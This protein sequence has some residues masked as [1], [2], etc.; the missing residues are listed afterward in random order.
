MRRLLMALLLG[1]LAALVQAQELTIDQVMEGEDFVGVSPSQVR[2]SGDNQHIYF[3]WREPDEKEEATYVISREGSGLRRLSKDEEEAEAWPRSG[4]WDRERE[5][6]LAVLQG[7]LYLYSPDGSRRALTQTRQRESNA[8]FSSDE[9]EVYFTRDNNLFTLSSQ[10]SAVVQ[11]TDFREG[12]APK[13]EKLSENEQFLKEQQEKLFEQFS[14]HR[15]DARERVEERRKKRDARALYFGKKES[16]SNLQLS[17]DGKYVL[18]QWIKRAS[19]SRSTTVPDFVTESGFSADRSSRPKVGDQQ[20]SRKLGI[21]RVE[22]GQVTWVEE[23]EDAA[24]I[25]GPVWNDSGR[26]AAI[27]VLSADFKDRWIYSLKLEDGEAASIDHLHDEAWVGGPAWNAFGWMP[28]GEDVYFISERDGWAHLYLAAHDG[29]NQRQ[30]T[31]GHW[32]VSSA[33]LS[34]DQAFWHLV[35]SE[36][37][38]GERHYYTM[39]LQGGPRIRITQA[40]GRHVVFLSPDERHLAVLFSS[41]NRPPELFYQPNQRGAERRQLMRSA[42]DD[43]LAFPW[44]EPQLVEF[45]ARDGASL[46]ARFYKP[47]RPAP[48]R[49]AVI[50][51]HGAG[52]LQNVHKWW[53]NYYREYMFH[54]ILMQRGYHVLDIDYRGS[55]GHGR[56]WRT[57]IYRRM[58]GKDLTD[59]VDGARWLVES[60]G[61]DPQRIGIYGGSYGGFITLMALFTEPDVFAAGAS[62]RPVTDWAHYN[63]SY[64]GRILNLPQGDKEAYERSS[65]IYFAQGLKGAL[66]IC[67]GMV[68]TNVHF[69]DT[70]RLAQRLIELRKEN[71]EVA[72]YPVEGHRFRNATSWADEYKRILR[73]FEENLK[74]SVLGSR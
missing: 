55:A 4:R 28:N 52:Y 54:H 36:Q 35:S 40:A 25:L 50:F 37:H 74:P 39:P 67:H 56:D 72:L 57:G 69:Q 15:K 68:D 60:Q 32:E 51:V 14:G 7:D 45:R 34:A 63:H 48:S 10:G 59:Q 61:V 71:W 33:R 21:Y 16:A 17:P 46:Q 23:A 11:V 47:A 8:G 1:G 24:M 19:E 12:S 20:P 9:A 53:S 5:R 30:L 70:V 44:R 49:P 22:D 66:L 31:S 27:W 13:E 26:R 58:G 41:S 38:W 73:L 62:L 29:S 18:F 2:W 65:P 42:R 3:R 43:F 6:F 64:T